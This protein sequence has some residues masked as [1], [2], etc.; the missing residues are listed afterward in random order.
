MAYSV[1]TAFVTI[2]PSLKGFQTRVGAGISAPLNDAGERAGKTSAERFTSR[3]KWAL[4]VGAVVGGALAV[5]AGGK[6]LKGAIRGRRPT[7]ASP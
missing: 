1:G 5:A 3:F 2:A 6:L 7:S 4:K